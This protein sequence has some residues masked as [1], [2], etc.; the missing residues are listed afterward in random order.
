[1]FSFYPDEII[2][3]DKEANIRSKMECSIVCTSPES[4]LGHGRWRNM[5]SFDIY[6][7]NLIG[8]IVDEACCISHW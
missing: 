6:K 8:T 4:I 5:I 7:E 1:M 3:E 2:G